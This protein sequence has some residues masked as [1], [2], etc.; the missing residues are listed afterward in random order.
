MSATDS[1]PRPC[2]SIAI[3]ELDEILDRVAASLAFSSPDPR[4]RTKEKY[5][6]RLRTNDTLLKVF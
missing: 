3:K 1:E 6:E 5:V 4:K 2:P